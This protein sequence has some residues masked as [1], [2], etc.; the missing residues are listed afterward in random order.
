MQPV[1]RTVIFAN[2][3]LPDPEYT[4]RLLRPTDRMIVANGGSRH[5]RALDVVPS[6][7][8]GDI[9]S[10]PPGIAT[11]L[12]HHEV[13]Q[14]QFPADKEAT[15]LEL[16]IA[17]AIEWGTDS[18]L[19]LGLAGNR[20]DHTL[21]NFALLAQASR[22]RIPI[23][24]MVGRQQVTPVWRRSQLEGN[25]GDGVSLI[26]W[27]GPARGVHTRGLRWNLD[28]E[29]LA[30]ESSRGISNVLVDPVAEIQLDEG[31]L[32]VIHHRTD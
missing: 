10:L 13:P 7:I 14:R 19:L 32:L 6:L 12:D 25:V 16:A 27:G 8:V 26:P 18:I 15:D 30:F 5:A 22:H 24:A 31:L 23:V 28:D 1:E 3:E 9:D 20:L 11:W 4:R 2:G 29:T 21:T 17:A